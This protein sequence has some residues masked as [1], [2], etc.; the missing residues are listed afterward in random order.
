VSRRAGSAPP[1]PPE[2]RTYPKG[3]RTRRAILREAASLATVDGLEGLSIGNLAAALGMSKSGL[4]AHFRS[5]QELQL[6]TVDEAARI[7]EDEV[8]APALAAPRGLPQLLALCEAFFA[9]LARRTFPGGCFFAGAVLEMGT[10]PGPVKERV[11]EFQTG[12]VALIRDFAAAAIE[13]HQLAS[14]EDPVQLAFE[15]NGIILSTDAS[16]VLH[17]DPAVLD[18]ARRVV[19]RRLRVRA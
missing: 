15:L 5:K 7:F 16:F 11:T 3:E 10:R 2:R 18:L 1:A 9:H 8:V 12:L 13:Q 6:A 14:D 4:Y 17:D 19:R